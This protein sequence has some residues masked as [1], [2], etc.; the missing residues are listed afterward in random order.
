MHDDPT[1]ADRRGELAEM[2]HHGRLYGE[3]FCEVYLDAAR[4]AAIVLDPATPRDPSASPRPIDDLR[5]AVALYGM[6]DEILQAADRY[7]RRARN[8]DPGSG[9]SA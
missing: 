3:L 9:P 1:H 6:A 7:E 2:H 4:Y 5:I 8:Q